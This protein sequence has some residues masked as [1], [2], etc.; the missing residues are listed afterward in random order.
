MCVF[1]RL[2]E[3][4]CRCQRRPEEGVRHPGLEVT[5][6]CELP[7]MGAR[8]RKLIAWPKYFELCG[9]FLETLGPL[10]VLPSLD[11]AARLSGC[12]HELWG[13]WVGALT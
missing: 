10:L 1:G 7:N 3:R 13:F 12:A 11:S 2:N 4:Q 5:R 8:N 6:R 9:H